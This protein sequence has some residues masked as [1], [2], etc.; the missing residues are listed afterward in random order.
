MLD[1]F[2]SSWTDF[3]FGFRRFTKYQIVTRLFLVLIILPIYRTFFSFLMRSR[4]HVV[5]ANN[6]IQEFLFSVQ[7]FAGT[8]ALIV[9][10]T[11]IIF[12]EIG[13][14]VVLSQQVFERSP[15]SSY[16]KVFSFCLGRARK[17]GIF[18][19]LLFL[20]YMA[21]L[22]PWLNVGVSNSLI[23]SLQIPPFITEYANA[24]LWMNLL[25]KGVSLAGIVYSIRWVFSLHLILLKDMRASQAM[26]HSG[27]LVMAHWWEMVK[28]LAILFVMNGILLLFLILVFVAVSALA[29][30]ML[31]AGLAGQR[32]F[33]ALFESLIALI[34]LAGTWV[35][36]PYA[37]HR[38]TVLLNRFEKIETIA[39]RVKTG[40]N[41]KW[42]DW[43][44]TRKKVIVAVLMIFVF[45]LVGLMEVYSQQL[46]Q[47]RPV[48][49]TAHRGD[50]ID[51]P[52]NT[53][54]G[55]EA[56]I[57]KGADYAEVDVQMIRD[58]TLILM[59]DGNGLRTT[60]VDLELSE[61]SRAEIVKLNAAAT[62]N[63][64]QEE[65][66]PFLQDA[67]EAA[68]GRIRLNLDLK[69]TGNQEELAQAVVEA[70]EAAKM[71]REV[72][73]TSLD[74]EVLASVEALKAELRTG[75]IVVLTLGDIEKIP[76]DFYSMEYSRVNESRVK[77]IHDAGK[78]VHVWTVNNEEEMDLV[79]GLGVDGLITDHVELVKQVLKE[80]EMLQIGQTQN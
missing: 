47:I 5:F 19:G 4:G 10:V 77:K 33:L 70:V 14:I 15:E 51:A 32:V 29:I 40:G 52:E 66:V 28:E 8:L 78:E 2:R 69:A 46:D 73:I 22:V 60:D 20:F 3:F 67:L 39:E 65:P 27:R 16:W 44:F 74:E 35:M 59:H 76:V 11:I 79:L 54:A 72:V 12:I 30:S 7:G 49:I 41:I 21:V 36:V 1:L 75:L 57:A 38:L 43:F 37:I 17:I 18:G 6:R 25:L 34:A 50:M 71:D 64:P 13:G 42:I 31:N 58:G 24:R 56:A 55:I 23:R 68:R 48:V 61:A 53:I 80:R 62:I 26:K 45:L 63:W 9:T